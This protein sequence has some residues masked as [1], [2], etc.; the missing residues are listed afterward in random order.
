MFGE[1]TDR[2]NDKKPYF[3][4]TGGSALDNGGHMNNAR[5]SINGA[6]NRTVED[7]RTALGNQFMGFQTRWWRM[8]EQC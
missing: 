7:R 1:G 4:I 5:Q 6:P 8:H 2:E 3:P